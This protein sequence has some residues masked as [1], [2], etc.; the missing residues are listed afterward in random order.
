MKFK[1]RRSEGRSK[2]GSEYNDEGPDRRTIRLEKWVSD[3]T[4]EGVLFTWC[5]ID[6]NIDCAAAGQNTPATYR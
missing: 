2:Y 4:E 3:Q 6:V 1:S 5:N